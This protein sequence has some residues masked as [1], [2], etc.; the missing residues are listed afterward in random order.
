MVYPGIVSSSGSRGHSARVILMPS[1]NSGSLTSANGLTYTWTVTA[2]NAERTA[3][4]L[5]ILQ[6][7]SEVHDEVYPNLSQMDVYHL[8]IDWI[9]AQPEF[10]KDDQDPINGD[11]VENGGKANLLNVAGYWVV[12]VGQGTLMVLIPIAAISIAV[13]FM[14]KVVQVGASIGDS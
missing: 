4:R 6:D 10:D 3:Y 8:A 5:T 1:W 13:G 12:G 2:T 7:G 14:R 9:Y 11:G